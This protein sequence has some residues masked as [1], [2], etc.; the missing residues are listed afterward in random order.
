MQKQKIEA[1][2]GVNGNERT[3]NERTCEKKT[4]DETKEKTI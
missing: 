3:R 1:T 4:E 2:S